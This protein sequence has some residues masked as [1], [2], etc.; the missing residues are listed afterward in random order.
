MGICMFELP[1]KTISEKIALVIWSVKTSVTLEKPVGIC[2]GGGSGD[3]FNCK[4][5]KVQN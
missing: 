5:V 4:E 2:E 1:K 3:G